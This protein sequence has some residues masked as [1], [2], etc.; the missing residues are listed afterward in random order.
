MSARTDAV[1]LRPRRRSRIWPVLALTL[2]LAGAAVWFTRERWMP[3][4]PDFSATARAERRT[5]ISTVRRIGVIQPLKEERIYTK[6]PGTILEIA[7]EGTV[8]QKD[9][10][11]LKLDP[12]LHEDALAKTL[13]AAAEATAG[14]KKV[15]EESL[16]ALNLARE[17]VK[18]Y[19]LRLELEQLRLDE[20]KKGPTE[21]DEVNAKMNLENNENLLKAKQETEKAIDSL[22]RVGFATQ[23]ELRQKQTDTIEQNFKVLDMML[24]YRK[25]KIVDNVKVR[26]QELKVN[27]ATKTRN[28]AQEKVVL[29]EANLKRDDERF[30]HTKEREDQTI[31]ELRRNVENTVYRAPCTGLVVPRMYRGRFAPGRSLGD[32]QEVLTMPDLSRMKVKLTVDEGHYSHIAP[33]MPANVVPA[34]WTGKPFKGSVIKVAEQGRDEFE[35]FQ[36]ATTDISGTANRKVFEVE[37]ELNENSPVLRLGLRC[38]VEIEVGRIEN[39]IVVPRAALLRQKDGDVFAPIADAMGES[40]R[41]K[42]KV[43]AESDLWAAVEGINEGERLLLMEAKN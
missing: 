40:Q 22:T 17:D 25:L 12:R 14:Y 8:V 15:R 13:E 38:D 42:I 31:L 11:V 4:L 21:I 7:T 5:F 6:L 18:S 2:L 36:E 27:D 3:H 35:Q 33:K 23:E 24:A 34:G 26:E 20:I 41:R 19:Q 16:K 32:G 39:A 10:I 30:A 1:F 37:I 43:V 29:L 9:D 28:A